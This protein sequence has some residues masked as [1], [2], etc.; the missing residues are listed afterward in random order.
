MSK[1]ITS[2]HAIRGN[3]KENNKFLVL[4]KVGTK[5]PKFQKLFSCCLFLDFAWF[6]YMMEGVI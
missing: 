5:K 4:V 3:E 6:R 2:I 1:N